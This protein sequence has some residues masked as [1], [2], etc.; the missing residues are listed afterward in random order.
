MEPVFRF[1]CACCGEVHEGAPGFAYDSPFYYASL[2]EDERSGLASLNSDLCTINDENFFIRT[3][4]EI[5]I[6]GINEP[7]TWGVWVSLSPGNYESYRERFDDPVQE[8]EYFGW[9]SNVLSYYP[10]TLNLK[11]AVH[12][13]SGDQRPWLELEPTDHPLSVDY[14]NG[15]SWE[16]AIEI[17]QIAMHGHDA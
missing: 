14:H 3:V 5:Q 2:P 6:Q 16:K 4:L 15:I 8:G 1:E 9:F 10:D 7:F 11:T 12:L 17:A 13:R